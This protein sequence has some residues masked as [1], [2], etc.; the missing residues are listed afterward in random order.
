MQLCGISVLAL[1]AD[2]GRFRC[3]LCIFN[4]S[5]QACR[6]G[7]AVGAV[8]FLVGT[9]LLVIDTLALLVPDLLEERASFNAF[10]QRGIDTLAST[11]LTTVWVA[12]FGLLLREWENRPFLMRR[13]M[14]R[15]VPLREIDGQA[16]LALCFMNFCIWVRKLTCMVSKLT[17]KLR[18]FGCLI[19][20]S[21]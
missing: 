8:G 11:A 10:A 21:W 5:D 16:T 15:G 18:N 4:S 19:R 2:K 12:C 17:R 1:I 9:V 3:E 20:P 6:L 7:M 13:A 14:E